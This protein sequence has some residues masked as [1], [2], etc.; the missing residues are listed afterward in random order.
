MKQTEA[1]E[2]NLGARIFW[3]VSLIWLRLSLQDWIDLK[4]K[5][6]CM[7]L[8]VLC[9][10]PSYS[11]LSNC[12]SLFHLEA[13]IQVCWGAFYCGVLFS[14]MTKFVLH[15]QIVLEDKLVGSG[16]KRLGCAVAFLF[17]LLHWSC[18]VPKNSSF[19]RSLSLKPDAQQRFLLLL[20]FFFQTL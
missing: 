4:C 19:T 13:F 5:I 7:K 20:M 14:V 16:S 8:W 12:G 15:C 9:W 2:I 1:I 6:D 11:F 10:R 18:F 3:Q 17:F